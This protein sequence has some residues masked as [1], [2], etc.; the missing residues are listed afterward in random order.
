MKLTLYE[1]DLRENHRGCPTSSVRFEHFNHRA[2]SAISVVGRAMFERRDNYNAIYPPSMHNPLC[3]PECQSENVEVSAWVNANT[4]VTADEGYDGPSGSTPF[5][6]H[7]CE[8]A[9]DRL[10]RKERS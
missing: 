3:C 10:V 9:V 8:D 2:Q 7:G 1:S 5:Y 4:R 6:C